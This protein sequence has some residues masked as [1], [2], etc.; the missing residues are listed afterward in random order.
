MGFVETQG[1]IGT[2][3]FMHPCFQSYF[4]KMLVLTF[5]HALYNVFSYSWKE[6]VLKLALWLGM[7]CGQ[8]C[9]QI[10]PHYLHF[11]RAMAGWFLS[12]RMCC[13][14]ILSMEGKLVL[15]IL[16]AALTTPQSDFLSVIVLFLNH[17]KGEEE[18]SSGVDA[19]NQSCVESRRGN[20]GW[21]WPSSAS[22]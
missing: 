2:L 9:L 7:L 6:A 8:C 12:L 22:W 13:V 10:L 3:E 5:W 19:F 15:L 16:P 1:C 17:V 21:V 11:N 14:Y 20:D 18:P 4:E